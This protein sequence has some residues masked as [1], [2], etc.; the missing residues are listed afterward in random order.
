VIT[1]VLGEWIARRQRITEELWF[2][3]DQLEQEFISFGYNPRVARKLARRRLGSL[4]KHRRQARTQ[5]NSR[6][7]D[8][9]SALLALWPG[10]PWVMPSIVGFTSLA[11]DLVLP[12]N[13][14]MAVP[15]AIWISVLLFVFPL[16]A[17]QALRSRS[18]L[19]Y[20]LYSIVSLLAASLATSA[21]WA[22]LL[23]IWRIP[24]WP[25]Q[26]W[27]VSIFVAALIAY[28]L[29]CWFSLR[30]WN[31]NRSCR[32][33]LC[34]RLLRLPDEQGRSGRLLLHTVTRSRV[35][36]YGHGSLTVTYWQNSW[37]SNGGFW[38][39]MLRTSCC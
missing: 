4:G 10:N 11:V 9:L 26:G 2:H 27:S 39:E 31:R 35:C 28:L 3:R 15:L 8:L 34:A 22:C 7:R 24:K 12:K 20:H 37:R 33:R 14:G 32:C 30:L 5:L 29:V 13:V 38:D 16:E 1:K 6:T 25:S 17:S 19:P 23:L 18:H 21:A 36:T